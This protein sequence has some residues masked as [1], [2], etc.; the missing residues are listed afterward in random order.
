MQFIEVLE[1]YINY[2]PHHQATDLTEVEEFALGDDGSG[3]TV[4]HS[5][6]ACCLSGPVNHCGS[7]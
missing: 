2:F 1:C 5:G 4:H 6:K 3:E 7:L